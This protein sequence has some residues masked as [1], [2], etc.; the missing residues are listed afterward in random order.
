MAACQIGSY[1]KGTM[2]RDHNVA[3][4]VVILKN[5]PTKETFQMLHTKIQEE[6]KKLLSTEIVERSNFVKIEANDNNGIDVFDCHAHVRILIATSNERKSTNVMQRYL[7]GI[8]HIRWFG[9]EAHRQHSTIKALIRILRD[10]TERF[11]GLKM[12][13]ARII[14][15]LVQLASLQHT[16]G[17]VLPIHKA[18]RRIFQLLAAGIFLPGSPGIIDPCGTIHKNIANSM[19]LD[20]R[21]ICCMT[22]Q[23][24]YRLHTFSSKM[25]ILIC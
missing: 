9:S 11:V 7:V 20:E 10:A 6:M 14:D 16:T 8:K 2:R 19:T 12:L 25:Q 5:L 4:I 1:K 18:F 13:N 21:D 15:L 3:D 24:S 17:E 22:A 23:V